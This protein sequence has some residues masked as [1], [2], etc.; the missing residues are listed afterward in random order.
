MD[1]GNEKRQS[2]LASVLFTE[3]NREVV[4]CFEMGKKGKAEKE[5]VF[6]FREGN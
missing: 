3:R 2:S 1:A 4:M 6:F 5:E